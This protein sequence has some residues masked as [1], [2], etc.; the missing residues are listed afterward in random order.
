ME[1]SYGSS[2]GNLWD[3]R[4]VR[5]ETGIGG[6]VYHG[7]A[8]CVYYIIVQTY[9]VGLHSR[10]HLMEFDAGIR[11]FAACDAPMRE[12][13]GAGVFCFIYLLE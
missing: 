9:K 5:C 8:D 3:G 11:Q 1:R 4:G 12:R 7:D 10:R 13:D 6:A 2:G